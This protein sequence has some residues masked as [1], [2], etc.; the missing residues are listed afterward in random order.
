MISSGSREKI[1]VMI[2]LSSGFP[3]VI[4][5]APDRRGRV[6][7]LRTSS[8]KRAF[9]APGSG[10]WHLK[11]CLARIGRTLLRNRSCSGLP[12]G[13]AAAERAAAVQKNKGQTAAGRNRI[14]MKSSKR[15]EQGAAGGAR[16]MGPNGE[17]VEKVPFPSV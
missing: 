7:S 2:S 9:R 17:F 5:T 14:V 13:F 10:P 4:G 6:A 16:K 11:Q 12:D 15:A 3:G 1:R 8:R